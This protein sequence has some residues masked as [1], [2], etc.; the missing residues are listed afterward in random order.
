[1]LKGTIKYSLLVISIWGLSACS[2]PRTII[3]NQENIRP[4][5]EPVVT[6][7]TIIPEIKEEILL[8]QGSKNPNL[9]NRVGVPKNTPLLGGGKNIY[10]EENIVTEPVKVSRNQVMERISFPIG[11]YKYLK[12]NG[13]STVSGTIYLENSHTSAKIK[14]QKIKLWLNPVT[15]YSRQWYQESYLGG[16]KLSK[17]DK[18]LYNYLKFTYSDRSGKFN[19]YGVPAGSYYLTGTIS[20][21][22][23]CG[24]KQTKSIRLVKRISV[25][26]GVTKVDLMK[27][28]P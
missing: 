21:S 24:F 22:K 12:K 18:R 3:I 20:C 14:G 8:G 25:G 17:T 28:V 16:Y 13:S 5:P 1:M 2:T 7:P 9:G 27:H 19:F 26:S 11:E 15:S 10:E 6:A 23:E 4:I